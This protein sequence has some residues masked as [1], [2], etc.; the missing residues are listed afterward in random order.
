MSSGP[1][2]AKSRVPRG[3]NTTP[4]R[5]ML[6]TMYNY[7]VIRDIAESI[8]AVL[9]SRRHKQPHKVSLRGEQQ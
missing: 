2:R 3:A 7:I 5:D 1:D 4:S 8:P 9:P 6:C